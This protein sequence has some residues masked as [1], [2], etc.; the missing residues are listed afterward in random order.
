MFQPTTQP[1]K[2]GRLIEPVASVAGAHPLHRVSCEVDGNVMNFLRPSA[3]LT[4]RTYS[5]G[6][7]ARF[8][9]TAC[10]AELRGH[11]AARAKKTFQQRG[12]IDIRIKGRKMQPE[13]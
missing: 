3:E 4:V 5:G 2:C 10:L 9:A 7:S 8:D 11:P 13:P 6:L 1:T 12:Q